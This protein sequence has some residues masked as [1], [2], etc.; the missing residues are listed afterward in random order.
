MGADLLECLPGLR[1]IV[2]ERTAGV[3]RKGVRNNRTVEGADRM[4][5]EE[6]SN[7]AAIDQAELGE[8]HRIKPEKNIERVHLHGKMGWNH[9]AVIQV[10]KDGS[11]HKLYV[12]LGK[13]RQAI[14]LHERTQSYG[15][16][17]YL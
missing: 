15:L 1:K 5:F 17:L 14:L 7:P 16:H 2:T 10:I 13:C 6:F 4:I 8:S 9:A 3:M 11:V 12:N